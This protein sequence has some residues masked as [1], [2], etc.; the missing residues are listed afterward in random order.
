MD[1]IQETT[2]FVEFTM[3][4]T[5]LT[6]SPTIKLGKVA[7]LDADYI[8]YLVTSR[9]HKRIKANEGQ[10]LEIFIK[11][12]PAIKETKEIVSDLFSKVK[13]PIVF[14]FSGSSWNTFR[15]HLAFEKEYKGNR[16]ENPDTDYDGKLQD[17]GTCMDYIVDNF[18]S[19]LFKDLEADDIVS[20]L[21]CDQTF[22]MSKDKDLLQVPGL[23]YDFSTNRVYEISPSQALYNLATQLITGDT[24]DNIAGLPGYGPKKAIQILSE[25]KKPSQYVNRALREYQKNYG[26]FEGTDRF[27]ETWMLVK[28]RSNW[29]KNFKDK[30]RKMF[31]LKES[32]L[33]VIKKEAKT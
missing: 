22:I 26:V 17:I 13:D 16:K 27:T 33:N 8:K 9:I 28:M 6:H 12:D 29:G 25:V 4:N 21:Q 14:C 5:T 11:E 18:P 15:Y 31:D 30:Y 1:I 19:L 32:I 20:A 3:T 7:L 10:R 23:H 2:E 24:T